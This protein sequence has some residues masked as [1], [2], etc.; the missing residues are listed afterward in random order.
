MPTLAGEYETAWNTSTT[1]KA[2]AAFD[3]IAG[4]ILAVAVMS[5]TNITSKVATLTN[6]G[7]ALVWTRV[8]N[9]VTNGR[10]HVEIQTATVVD[11]TSGMVV[12]ASWTGGVEWG[13]SVCQ[14]RT[15]D[16]ASNATSS[17]SAAGAPSA[18]LTTTADNSFILVGAGDVNAADGSGRVW[19]QP[20]PLTELLYFNDAA[21]TAYLGYHTDAGT[22]GANT[23]GLSAPSMNYSMAAV[24]VT[25]A[26]EPPLPEQ[27]DLITNL[28]AR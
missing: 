8:A 15:A 17:T 28:H 26:V 4:D 23:V 3:V 22:A 1:P 24:E 6:T 7:T 27:T 5:R 19:R 18:V 14:L 25:Q 2:L 20:T 21:W 11:D 12:S 16:D 13:T 9:E 10:P